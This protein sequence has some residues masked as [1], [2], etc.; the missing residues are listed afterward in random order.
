MHLVDGSVTHVPAL[1]LTVVSEQNVSLELSLRRCCDEIPVGTLGG[2]V[3]PLHV[4]S[5]THHVRPNGKGA[6][7]FL[8][9]H[10]DG[11]STLSHLAYA[12]AG[13]AE[14]GLA[15]LVESFLCLVPAL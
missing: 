2:T 7:C 10:A 6:E 4:S 14:N 13:I 8:Q 9:G 11:D 5:F 1:H 12:L 3:E 15:G